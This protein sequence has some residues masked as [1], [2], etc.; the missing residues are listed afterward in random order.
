MHAGADGRMS[1]SSPVPPCYSQWKPPHGHTL[2]DLLKSIE[3]CFMEPKKM[4]K[5][6]EKCCSECYSEAREF[7]DDRR[8][9]ISK[10]FQVLQETVDTDSDSD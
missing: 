4:A 10:S 1:E 2:Y 9:Y 6:A 7:L 8:A 3:Y 5:L